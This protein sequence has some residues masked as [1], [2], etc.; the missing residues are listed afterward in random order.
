MSTWFLGSCS[1]DKC[2]WH[3][4]DLLIALDVHLEDGVTELILEIE[5]IKGTACG[6]GLLATSFTSLGF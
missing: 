2:R 1:Q 5:D 6:K 3:E 4:Q